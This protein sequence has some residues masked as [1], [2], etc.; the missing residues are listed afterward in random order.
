MSART[1]RR[2]AFFVAFLRVFGVFLGLAQP[3][4]LRQRLRLWTRQAKGGDEEIQIRVTGNGFIH[5]QVRIMVGTLVE[6]GRGER[7]ADSIPELFGGKRAEA[8]FLAPAQGL[9]LMEV[10]Y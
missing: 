7:T 3:R 8:G 6:V 4:T 5:N 1:D 2:A 9:C 10:T